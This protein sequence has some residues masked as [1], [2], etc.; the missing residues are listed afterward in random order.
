MPAVHEVNRQSD[1]E[2]RKEAQPGQNRKTGHQQNTKEDAEHRCS[3]AARRTE[4][5]VP[6]GIAVA[7]NDD[8]DRDQGEREKRADVR[9]IGERT[10]VQDPGG[11]A[12]DETGDPRRRR[13]RSKSR[14][15]SP[16]EFRQ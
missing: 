11:N 4:S 12:D 2:P 15:N 16:E 5:A 1:R 13:R 7:Q 6:T 9:K 10:D 14:M 8:A 3:D